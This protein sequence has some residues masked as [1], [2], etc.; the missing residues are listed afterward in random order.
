MGEL[1]YTDLHWGTRPGR[2]LTGK[3]LRS[4]NGRSIGT[5]RTVSYTTVKGTPEV[6]E[7]KFSIAGGR[8][9]YLLE[10]TRRGA[11]ELGPGV[12]SAKAVTL[13]RVVDVEMTD[14]R[15]II[16]PFYWVVTDQDGS[17]IWLSSD[18]RF[19]AEVQFEQR[20]SGGP[21]VTVRGIEG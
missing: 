7:H 2:E 4:G 11:H 9:P 21:R 14:G 17:S 10:A 12:D 19:P 16:L 6:W 20:A 15:R 1:N 3:S 5:M 18:G 13:G 8:R